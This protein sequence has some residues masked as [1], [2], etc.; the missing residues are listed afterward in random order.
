MYPLLGMVAHNMSPETFIPILDR[1]KELQDMIKQYF[2]SQDEDKLFDITDEEWD[3][4]KSILEKYNVSIGLNGAVFTKE[5]KGD[6][7]ILI[8]KIYTERKQKK[9]KMFE[10]ETLK[11]QSTGQ[12]YEKYQHLQTLMDTDQM[13]LKIM[14]NSLYGAFAQRYFSLYNED[15]ARAITINGRFFIKHM[16]NFIED[17][18]QNIKKVDYYKIYNDTDSGYFTLDPIV[19]S[20]SKLQSTE[21][22]RDFCNNFFE[23]YIQKTINKSIDDFSKKTNAYKKE[24]IGAE[25]EIIADAGIWV[26]KK[27]YIARVL[28]NEG[29]VYKEPYMKIMGLEII[30]G[31]TAPWSKKYLKESIS[32][33]LDKTAKEVKNWLKEIKQG[34]TEANL[35]DIAKKIGVNKLSDPKWGTVQDG[36]N[37]TPPF[38]SK[39]A[40][41][42]NNY[43]AKHNLQEQ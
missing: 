25:R 20:I 26:A 27:K 24:V 33:I 10:Y 21:Q 9:K 19:S 11:L 13:T 42:T 37:V 2:N 18:L 30:Q 31:G 23:K 39:A 36:R 16:S 12:E 43:I 38:N 17:T 5:V 3:Y 29:V 6:I 34:Y 22:K 4:I 14:M 7:P 32:I 41:A 1:P 35:E 40:I 28:D 15:L 8:E